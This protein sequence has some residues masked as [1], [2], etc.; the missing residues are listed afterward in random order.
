MIPRPYPCLCIECPECGAVFMA[1]A[2]NHFDI[3][4]AEL[5]EDIKRYAKEGMNASF[6]NNNEFKLHLCEHVK[7]K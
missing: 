6:K 2:L 5:I 3:E 4:D 1:S 7:N